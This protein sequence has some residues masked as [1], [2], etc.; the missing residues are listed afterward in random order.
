MRW[1]VITWHDGFGSAWL[2]NHPRQ[3]LV[4]NES[5]QPED[6]SIAIL[7]PELGA[8][9]SSSHVVIAFPLKSASGALRA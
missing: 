2:S 1:L 6:D 5:S 8:S 3:T 7:P 9:S 4:A